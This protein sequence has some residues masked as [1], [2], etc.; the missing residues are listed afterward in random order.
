MARGKQTCKILKEIRRQIAEAK[1]SSSPHRNVAD[2]GLPRL[3]A[4][5]SGSCAR[6][7]AAA[8]A[9]RSRHPL[10][11]ADDLRCGTA[12]FEKGAS[13]L[14]SFRGIV[15]SGDVRRYI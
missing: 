14:Q 7:L 10:H 6:S 12:S 8:V 9:S 3:P 2:K 5:W 4:D 1:T 11:D 13:G 15:L